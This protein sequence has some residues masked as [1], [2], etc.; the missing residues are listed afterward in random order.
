VGEGFIRESGAL[1]CAAHC[2]EGVSTKIAVSLKA[3]G[4]FAFGPEY[5]GKWISE[6]PY[7]ARVPVVL[8][9]AFGATFLLAVARALIVFVPL[10]V[11]VLLY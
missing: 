1:E 2:D 8:A 7:R 10:V 11:F 5:T 6:H 3:G 4:Y 9:F